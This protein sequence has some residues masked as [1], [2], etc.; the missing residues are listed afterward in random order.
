[1]VAETAAQIELD[2]IKLYNPTKFKPRL[3]NFEEH[4]RVQM[5]I[6]PVFVSQRLGNYKKAVGKPS[7]SD[8]VSIERNPH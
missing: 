8:R 7:I 5:N 6:K 4:A 2:F 3:N 1:M